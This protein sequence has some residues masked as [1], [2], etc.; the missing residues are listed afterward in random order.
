MIIKNANYSAEKDA[1]LNIISAAINF[2]NIDE[3][4]GSQVYGR[5]AIT[6]EQAKQLEAK[7]IMPA[8]VIE[9]ILVEILGLGIDEDDVAR[10][11]ALEN[12]LMKKTAEIEGLNASI[13]EKAEHIMTTATMKAEEI[14]KQAQVEVEMQV[15]SI[16]KAVK[17]LIKIDELA[18]EDIA[19]L[20]A[21]YEPWIA[22]EAVAVGDIRSYEDKLYK[23]V[24]AHTT[25][26]DWMPPATPALWIEIAPPV[27]DDGEEI[28]P[29]WK[30]PT[31]AH[32]AYNTGDRVLFEGK[33][34]ESLIDA[35][36]WSPS[37]YAQGWKEVAV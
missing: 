5:I 7:E 27:T 33:V 11:V 29:E 10:F 21:L 18:P 17:S 35:N 34:Y 12:E 3:R 19:E 1:D 8:D 24:Q 13:E 2:T 37:D 4:T 9:P 22:D 25:Q 31:G 14:T 20:V 26:A 32:D 30:Q 23:V 15:Q 6:N 28:V 36:T 16:R